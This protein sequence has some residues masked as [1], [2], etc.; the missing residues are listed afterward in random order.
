MLR[1]G[2]VAVASIPF[3]GWLLATDAAFAAELSRA[4]F[5]PYTG[6]RFGMVSPYAGTALTLVAVEDLPHA[7]AGHPRCFS[8]TFRVAS[9]ESPASGTWVLKHPVLGRISLFLVPVGRAG[10][11]Q[12][13]FNAQP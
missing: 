11:L 3:G 1:G 4:S 13:V 6:K 12:A 5:T 2:L 8:L 10:D 7:A 9:G